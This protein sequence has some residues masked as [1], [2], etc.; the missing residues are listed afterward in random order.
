MISAI[1]TMR[2]RSCMIPVPYDRRGHGPDA[3]S[4]TVRELFSRIDA[5]LSQ[6]I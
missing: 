6:H 5:M 4:G 1:P 2:S 3:D